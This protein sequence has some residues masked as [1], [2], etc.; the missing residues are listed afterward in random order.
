[1]TQVCEVAK[2][3]VFF[4]LFYVYMYFSHMCTSAPCAYS[5]LGG[6]YKT[7]DSEEQELEMAV[8]VRGPVTGFGPLLPCRFEF[9]SSGQAAGAVTECALLQAP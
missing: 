5:A 8:V 7:L 9:T 1:M 3:Q 2:N 6:Q 4:L